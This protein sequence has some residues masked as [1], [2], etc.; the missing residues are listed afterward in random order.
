MTV[1]ALPDPLP[2][3]AGWL[4]TRAGRVRWYASGAG[5]P[6]LLL[7][8]FNAAASSFEMLP[9]YRAL[10]R[11][12]RAVA[13]DW[14]GFGRSERPDLAYDAIL[15]EDVLATVLKTLLPDERVDVVALS[16]TAQYAVV[17]AAAD[18]ARF[19]RLVLLSPT[20]FG[21]F[22]GR[23]GGRGRAAWRALRV[24]GTGPLLFGVLARRRVIAWFYRQI[25]ADTAGVPGSLVEYAWRTAQQRGAARAPL[26]F[27]CGLL[28]DGRARAAYQALSVPALLLFGSAPRF[29]DPGAASDLV[30]ANP[31]LH[32]AEVAASGDLPQWER[33]AA[34]LEAIQAFLDQAA[35]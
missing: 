31:T 10:S 5:R 14:P 22:G 9:I 12:R 34:T 25:F 16:L 19:G 1:P 35:R 13:F 26:R 24:T 17:L 18:P 23:P 29:T 8:S 4:D 6:V 15:F 21:R 2:G 3:E 11:D 7:H 30:A 32:V 28:N 20:G 27:V 33:P